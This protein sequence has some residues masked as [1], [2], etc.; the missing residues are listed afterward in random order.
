MFFRSILHIDYVA[1][2]ADHCSHNVHPSHT[3]SRRADGLA[4]KVGENPH[5]GVAGLSDDYEG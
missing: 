1:A 2:C 5:L 3:L 4:P